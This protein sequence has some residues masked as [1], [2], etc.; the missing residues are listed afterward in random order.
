MDSTPDLYRA[1]VATL[2]AGHGGA[3]EAQGYAALLVHA[4]AVQPVSRF[5]DR[6]WPF[7]PT[8]T[9]AH[10][11]PLVEPESWLLIEPGKRPRVL[12]GYQAGFW[13]GPPP[14]APDWV[15]SEIDVRSIAPDKLAAEL[16][17]GRLAFVGEDPSRAAALGIAHPNPPA[18]VAAFD[19]IRTR[20][21]DYERACLLAATRRA[22]AGHQHAFALFRGQP[23]SELELHLEFLDA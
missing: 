11:L 5:D 7:K 21:T 6:D 16:P 1:H 19:Q 4:G 9:F 10:W 23:M 2:Q 13:D 15:W 8:P 12:R 18:V 14:A 20:K 17:T 3:L 22:V